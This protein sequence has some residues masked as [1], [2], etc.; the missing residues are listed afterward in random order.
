MKLETRI[1]RLTITPE[2]EPIFSERA[3]HIEIVDEAAGEYLVIT[4][5]QGNINNDNRSIAIDP[6][7]WETIKSAI[8]QM[9]TIIRK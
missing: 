9:L 3:T 7:E 8:E 4:Q 5:E 1:T 2:D 6:S